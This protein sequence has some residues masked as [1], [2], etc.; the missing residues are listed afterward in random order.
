[1][2]K[3]YGKKI[4]KRSMYMLIYLG[5]FRENQIASEH[6]AINASVERNSNPSC[7]WPL[8]IC[9]ICTEAVAIHL[10]ANKNHFPLPTRKRQVAKFCCW[11]KLQAN[12][13]K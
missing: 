9:P 12:L 4:K 7:C 6:I 13:K 2:L 8:N 3:D 11:K 1:M 5:L 10:T